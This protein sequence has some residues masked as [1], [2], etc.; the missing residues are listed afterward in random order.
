MA[1][2]HPANFP[3]LRD[4]STASVIPDL[5]RYKDQIAGLLWEFEKQFQIFSNPKTEFT[6]FRSPFTVSA[7]DVPV[8]MEREIIK[9][10]C[11]VEFE[12]Q[13]CLCGLKQIFFIYLFYLLPGYP[14]VTALAAKML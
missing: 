5:S 14:K 2:G 10:Q 1:S 4:V 11:D 3:C 9:L 8:D 12:G 6:V 13:I 7:S